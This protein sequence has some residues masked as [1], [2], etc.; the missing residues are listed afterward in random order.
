M[1]DSKQHGRKALEW[2]DEPIHVAPGPDWVNM[3]DEERKTWQQKVL[4]NLQPVSMNFSSP[5]PDPADIEKLRKELENS[6]FGPEQ[7]V[8]SFTPPGIYMHSLNDQGEPG[9]IPP[10]TVCLTGTLRLGDMPPGFDFYSSLM[11]Q[12][13]MVRVRSAVKLMP[14]GKTVHF[15]FEDVLQDDVPGQAEVPSDEQLT[16][17]V[18]ELKGYFRAA[19]RQE[20]NCPPPEEK[21]RSNRGYEFL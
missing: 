14:D 6:F 2:L 3:T 10:R 17:L 7:S 18:Q 15:E 5:P 19:G 16:S 12:E 9:P 8:M 4:S 21:P 20:G 13:G 1:A 11:P